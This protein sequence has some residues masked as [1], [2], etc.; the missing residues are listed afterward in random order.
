VSRGSKD[1]GFTRG[2][3]SNI[4]YLCDYLYGQEVYYE[5]MVN[6]YRDVDYFV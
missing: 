4:L 3:L 6:S 1:P 2:N 5:N